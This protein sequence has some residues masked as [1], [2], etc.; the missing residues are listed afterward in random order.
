[1]KK[2]GGSFHLSQSL[3]LLD[4]LDD[5]S[6][7]PS[8][9]PLNFYENFKSFNKIEDLLQ[10]Q[11][12]CIELLKPNKN[13]V[14]KAP[15]GSGK[16]LLSDLFVLHCL[17]SKPKK[18][19]LSIVPLVSL[20]QE[21][22]NKLRT[23]CENLDYKCTSLGFS[24]TSN[25]L[26][27]DVII[28]TIE[29]AN[30]LIC[31][32][33]QKGSI[34]SI[35]SVIVDEAQFLGDKSRG[36]ILEMLLTKLKYYQIQIFMI[37]G[38]I[39]NISEVAQ[40]LDAILFIN[41]KTTLEAKEYVKVDNKIY[42]KTGELKEVIEEIP[43]D[44][45][46]IV[47]VVQRAIKKGAI[48]IFASSKHMCETLARHLVSFLHFDAE[49][50]SKDVREEEIKLGCTINKVE[51]VSKGV[52]CHHGDMKVE[53][54]RLI[55][56][57][58]RKGIIKILVCTSTLAFGVNL[59]CRTV[60]V[61]GI[62]V[63]NIK[64]TNTLYKNMVSRVARIGN[65]YKGE[66]MI[67]CKELELDKAL[68]LQANSNK[69]TFIDST[70]KDTSLGLKRLILEAICLNI[71]NDVETLLEYTR[72][73]FLF[74]KAP[75][76][77]EES[78]KDALSFLEE[79]ELILIQCGLYISTKL[80]LAICETGL[81][82][83][84]MLITY[85]DM[86]KA[87][88]KALIGEPL[89]LTYLVTPVLLHVPVKWEAYRKLYLY[90]SVSE[91]KVA[92]VIGID[93]EYII[94]AIQV[95]PPS[96]STKL[97]KG[98]LRNSGID[99]RV[100]ASCRHVRFYYALILNKLVKG[101][102]IQEHFGVSIGQ[103]QALLSKT[104]MFVKKAVQLTKRLNW[105]NLHLLLAHYQ[106]SVTFG[107]HEELNELLRFG[108]L[109]VPQ[110][111]AIYEAGYTKLQHLAYGDP[112]TI[113]NALLCAIDW[114][115]YYSKEDVGSFENVIPPSMEDTLNIIAMAKKECRR[116]KRLLRK[117]KHK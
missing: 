95:E 75:E 114:K 33:V 44:N 73:T 65:N 115:L 18:K 111:R 82:P 96:L 36:G 42:N 20:I 83:E 99:S 109:S 56:R 10:W 71:A 93:E 76:V 6:Y 86:A 37:T 40:W 8:C 108:M 41:E 2:R 31:E 87:N 103:V 77:I 30:I 88:T 5:D 34:Q 64:L 48:L 89:F 106:D 101:I 12:D 66:C 13:F 69:G 26:E 21:R 110:A 25:I 78:L 4:V 94:M 81:F 74:V 28:C 11:K 58:Y 117:I 3:S 22:N 61:Y 63:G 70:L 98:K 23:L 52:A 67:I 15:L 50:L 55:E 84:E 57:F 85:F 97:F 54:R 51:W 80:G 90:L 19:V 53:E 32:L 39:G 45:M 116:R 49:I 113:M 60:I 46:K 17:S 27:F 38:T 68:I 112:S 16:S 102:D 43:K 1:M 29:R 7:C 105:H 104:P 9:I 35:A 47:A 92:D 107:Q 24:Y 100:I 72:E 62:T 79:N 14:V 91:R 59:P